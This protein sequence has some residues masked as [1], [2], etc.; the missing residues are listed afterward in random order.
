M[1]ESEDVRRAA[2]LHVK[3][4]HATFV[5]LLP[6]KI[7]LMKEKDMYMLSYEKYAYYSF[8]NRYELKSFSQSLKR[9]RLV[10]QKSK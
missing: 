1:S 9:E 7:I 5:H 8:A 2:F 4:I 3:V 6:K 10:F